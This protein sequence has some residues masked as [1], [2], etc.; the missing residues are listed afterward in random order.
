VHR[1][2]HSPRRGCPLT[3]KNKNENLRDELA[4]ASTQVDE[5]LSH[6]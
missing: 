1:P 4:R 3:D 2:G 6:D 5:Y